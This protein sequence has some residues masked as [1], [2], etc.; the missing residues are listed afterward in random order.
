MKSSSFQE[1]DRHRKEM[2]VNEGRDE[3]LG[4]G[5]VWGRDWHIAGYG[6]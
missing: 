1:E 4:R 3:G 2:Q 6:A 5:G